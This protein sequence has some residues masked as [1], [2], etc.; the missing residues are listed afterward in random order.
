MLTAMSYRVVEM[1]EEYYMKSPLY[2]VSSLPVK[3]VRDR[4]GKKHYV[5]N[6]LSFGGTFIIA[7]D[8]NGNIV[9]IELAPDLIPVMQQAAQMRQ[10]T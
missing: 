8:L 3:V 9:K 1:E 6:I 2:Y 10:S 5:R 7:E 4:Y